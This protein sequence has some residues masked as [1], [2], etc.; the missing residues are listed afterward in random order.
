MSK[1]WEKKLSDKNDPYSSTAD[2]QNSYEVYIYHS[3]PNIT[4]VWFNNECDTGSYIMGQR[5]TKRGFKIY[6]V[7]VYH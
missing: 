3:V 4:T 7:H 2:E 6:Q 5:A 1:R